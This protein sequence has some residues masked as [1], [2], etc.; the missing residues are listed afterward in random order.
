MKTVRK[1]IIFTLA[2]ALV[3]GGV[4]VVT[5]STVGAIVATKSVLRAARSSSPP[6]QVLSHSPVSD[7]T[8]PPKAQISVTFGSSV[9]SLTETLRVKVSDDSGEQIPGG[10][11]FNDDATAVSFQPLTPFSPGEKHVRVTVGG[12]DDRD[13]VADWAFTVQ[14]VGTLTSGPGGTV[15]LVAAPKTHDAVIAEILRAEG[16]DEFLTIT[17]GELTSSLLE[18]HAVVIV[19][20]GAADRLD[21]SLASPLQD[22]VERGGGLVVSTPR[23]VLAKLAGLTPTG[24]S[25]QEGYL[26]VVGDRAPGQGIVDVPMQFHGDAEEYAVA[27]D[28]TTIAQLYADSSQSLDRPAVSI[29]KIGS[30]AVAAFAYD[31]GQ[32]IFEARQ[33]NPAWAETERDGK[34]PIR[35]DDLFHGGDE[36]DFVDLSR[37]QIPQADEQMRLLTNIVVELHEPSG[38]MP[39]FW[40]FP[41]DIKA[42]LVMAA[43]DHG[44]ESGTQQ[45]FDRMLDLSTTGCDITKWQCPR[46]TSWMYPTSGLTDAQA[47]T[48]AAAG[49]DLGVHVTTQ[50][51]NWTPAIL[52]RDFTRSIR[53]FRLAYPS[54]PPQVGSRVHCIAWSD[55]ASLPKIERTW[56]IRMDLNYYNWPSEWIGKDPGFMTGSGLPMRF[57]DT[58]GE[59]IDVYQLETHLVNESWDASPVPVE[60]MLERA[61]GPDGFYGAFG[62]HYDFS[63]DFD[64]QL[65][66]VATRLKVPMISAAQLLEWTDSR[67][68]SSIEDYDWANGT[69]SFTVHADEQTNGALTVLLPL[70][71]ESGRLSTVSQDGRRVTY[72]TQTIKGVEY[73]FL[74]AASGEMTAEYSRH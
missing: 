1:P 24:A 17:P 74:T 41:D 10:V 11:V 58:D 55:W 35:P 44:T 45:S 56:D 48:Y 21:A 5:G 53:A 43:D 20:S 49:F 72:Q 46:A 33:G 52:T 63:D 73:A 27:A 61:L 68:A 2:V 23:G 67:A 16:I 6:A 7:A 9:R 57:S 59:L 32:S 50:C 42:A 70:E 22:W 3:L 26:R 29:R 37:F 60:K 69:L 40:Y 47:S 30:G 25:V 64:R 15:L 71:S 65:M 12:P 18:K 62:T 4:L 13:E 31:L 38:P 14:S 19:G 28:T 8:V 54:L 51:Q 39:R 66:N 36:N 34:Y